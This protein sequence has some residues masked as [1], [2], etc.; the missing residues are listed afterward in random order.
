MLRRQEIVISMLTTLSIRSGFSNRIR[1]L[2]P[3]IYK[4][5][6]SNS[7]LRIDFVPILCFFFSYGYTNENKVM[8]FHSRTTLVTS[9]HNKFSLKLKTCIILVEMSLLWVSLI[10][11]HSTSVYPKRRWIGRCNLNARRTITEAVHCMES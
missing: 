4:V 2:S 10:G 9:L 6:G 3:K 5:N 7:S 11:W 1:V 8:H